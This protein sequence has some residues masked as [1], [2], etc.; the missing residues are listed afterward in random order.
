MKPA[1]LSVSGLVTD[2]MA[3]RACVNLLKIDC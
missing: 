1:P 2:L 3:S